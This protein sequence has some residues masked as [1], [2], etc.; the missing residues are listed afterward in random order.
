MSIKSITIADFKIKK[1]D[2][3]IIIIDI[4]DKKSY[5]MNNIPGSKNY[6]SSDI[7]ELSEMEDKK[8]ANII[9]CCYRGNSSQK[10]VHFLYQCGFKNVYNLTGGFEAWKNS[11]NSE[12]L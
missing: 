6:N 3:N 9:V 7:I 1:K 4:R 10:I 11:L 8:E 12:K 2:K 5:M